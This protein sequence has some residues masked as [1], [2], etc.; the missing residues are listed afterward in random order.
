MRFKNKKL[1]CSL[2][3]AGC[4][5]VGGAGAIATFDRAD[6]P[7]V[8]ALAMPVGEFADTYYLNDTLEMPVSVE[9]ELDGKT[10]SFTDGVLYYP[11]GVALQKN[12]YTLDQTGEYKVVYTLSADGKTLQTTKIF[13]V[14]EKNWSVSMA[15]SSVKYG[16]LITRVEASTLETL[17][18]LTVTL[19]DGDTFNYNVPIDLSKNTINDIVTINPVTIDKETGETSLMVT[20]EPSA[21]NIVVR[22]TD[23]Y[24]ESNSV[25]FL[26][27]YTPG[28]SIYGRAGTPEQ[29][30]SGI[31]RDENRLF[32][33]TRAVYIDGNRHLV[34]YSRYG[35]PLK[36]GSA[37]GSANGFTW[38]FNNE[39]NRVY[40]EHQR[41]LAGGDLVTD[42]GNADIYDDKVFKGFTTGEVY[43][44]VTAIGYNDATVSFEL[45]RI[46]GAEGDVLKSSDYKDTTAPILSVDY[47]P[48]TGNAVYV[49]QGETVRVFDAAAIDVSNATVDVSVYYNYESTKKTSVYLKDGA[50]TATQPGAYT[51]VY[52]ATDFYGNSTQQKVVVNSVKTESGKAIDFDVEKLASLSAGVEVKIPAPEVVGLNG[53]VTV[54]TTV[55]DP[56]GNKTS[57]SGAYVPLYVGEYTLSYRYFDAV[58]EYEYSYQVSGV[59]SD[60]SRF[61]GTLS[62]PRYF[63]K[64][65]KYSL[66]D[67][68][69]SLRRLIL[70]STSSMTAAIISLQTLTNSP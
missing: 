38:R 69:Q 70:N 28:S 55:T 4:I 25:D 32:S 26:L 52:T 18:G 54:E 31:E 13:T 65:A 56:K 51:I 22:L 57:V 68:R 37:A 53:D 10:Y 14:I 40:L 63:I 6:V 17:D 43:L 27:W 16:P 7:Q 23:A 3:V 42:I 9:A 44:S 15:D 8:Y 49:A 67:L 2:L 50:F 33:D 30:V 5:T 58:R 21:Q 61:L 35:C 46:G 19:A 59:A 66:E 45:G 34:W 39:T 24:D 48:T 47:T 62:M 20:N 41:S 11:N 64:G 12:E 1:I 29:G 36:T 60:A